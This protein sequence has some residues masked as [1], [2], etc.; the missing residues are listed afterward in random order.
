MNNPNPPATGDPNTANITVRL[1]N[2]EFRQKLSF[3]HYV[4]L[5]LLT[6]G[7]L[8]GVVYA[9]NYA[10]KDGQDN[11][12]FTAYNAAYKQFKTTEVKRDFIAITRYGD[13][14]VPAGIKA[15]E[16][17][18]ADGEMVWELPLKIRVKGE[19]L[20]IQVPE[21]P[22]EGPP[23]STPPPPSGDTAVPAPDADGP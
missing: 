8:I 15:K 20:N 18:A 12:D 3:G 19:M 10:Y 17:V 22:G 1:D 9:Y 13:F 7:C 14:K 21:L 11:P 4:V 5:I 16:V 23:T 6:I 2:D